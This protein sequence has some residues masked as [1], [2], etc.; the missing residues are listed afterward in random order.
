MATPA[1][2]KSNVYGLLLRSSYVYMYL[3]SIIR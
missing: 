1:T 2:C 3:L